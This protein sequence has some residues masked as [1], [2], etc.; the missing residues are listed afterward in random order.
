VET[1]VYSSV[2]TADIYKLN[3]TKE[4]T[5]E[6]D[7]PEPPDDNSKSK[8]KRKKAPPVFAE[9]SDEMKLAQLLVR[10]MLKNNDKCKK[11][12]QKPA[13]WQRW[14]K[15]MNEM[16]RIDRHSPKDVQEMILFSQWHHF[17][18]K[19]ILSPGNLRDK[20]DRLVLEKQEAEEK[21]DGDIS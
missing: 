16:L 15:H 19:N 11:V 10:R 2:E 6:L 14:C 3:Q 5:P 1:A 18:K 9:D 17:W 7:A 20:W 12:P 8:G 13:D 4:D 21:A